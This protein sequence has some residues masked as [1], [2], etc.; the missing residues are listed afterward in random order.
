MFLLCWEVY[1]LMEIAF[2]LWNQSLHWFSAK[3]TLIE[4]GEYM[5]FNGV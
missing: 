3:R 2:N 1:V 5:R 4:G